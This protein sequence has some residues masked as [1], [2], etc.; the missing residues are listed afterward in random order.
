MDAYKLILYT[1]S[2]CPVCGPFAERVVKIAAE[3][4]LQLEILDIEDDDPYHASVRSL[5]TLAVLRDGKVWNVLGGAYSETETRE[6]IKI[7][8][9]WT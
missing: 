5:P 6:W 9:H 3:L 4:N 8:I 1:S 7:Q 2:H